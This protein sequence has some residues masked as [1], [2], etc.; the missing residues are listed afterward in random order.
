MWIRFDA[1]AVTCETKWKL[2]ATCK[3]IHSTSFRNESIKMLIVLIQSVE[4]HIE[5][6]FMGKGD[7]CLIRNQVSANQMTSTNEIING[8]IFISVRLDE[9]KKIRDEN[10]I[11]WC[12][13]PSIWNERTTERV[14]FVRA[15][16]EAFPLLICLV[17][18]NSH[19]TIA[20]WCGKMKCRVFVGVFKSNK[21]LRWK[22]KNA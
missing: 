20:K 8:T 1:I 10:Y 4:M 6:H 3:N 13:V 18:G 5:R 9:K 15:F 12:Y 19:C 22:R 16:H 17:S 11:L 14:G 7:I 2:F 21:K